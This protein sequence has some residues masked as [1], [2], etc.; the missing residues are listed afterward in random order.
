MMTTNYKSKRIKKKGK[1]MAGN[2]VETMK[3]KG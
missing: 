3:K 1:R 2:K